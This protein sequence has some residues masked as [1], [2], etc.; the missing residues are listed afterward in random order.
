MGKTATL[1][2]VLVLFVTCVFTFVPVKGEYGTIVVPD[3]YATL[4]LAIQNAGEGD[5]VFV[6]KGTYQE[7]TITINKSISLIGEGVNETILSFNPPLVEAYILF[8][9]LVWVPDTAIKIEANDVKLQGFTIDLPKENYGVFNGIHAVGDGISLIDNEVANRSTVYLR[10]S[11]LNVTGNLM[12]GD[13]EVAGSNITIANN[14]I[15]QTLKV[16]GTFN[17]I[18]ANKIGGGYYF[19]CIHLI[20]S[21]NCV[22]D[23]SFSSMEMKNSSSNFIV[24]NSFMKLDLTKFDGGCFDNIIS[25]NQVKGNFGVNDGIWLWDGKNNIITANNIRNCETG[26]TLGT[27]HRTAGENSIYL[28]NFVNN[29]NHVVSLSG[30]NHTVNRFDNGTKGNY[31]DDYHGNDLNW[32]GVGD[33]PYT[34]K[35]THWDEEQQKDVTI[36]FFQDNYP[37]MSTFDIE[38]FSVELPEWAHT[39][40]R[41]LPDPETAEP[42]PTTLFIASVITIVAVTLGLLAYFKKRKH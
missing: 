24:G 37:L 38:G 3:D 41:H 22:V 9:N 16:Q 39:T 42:F 12:L 40:L 31:Y 5:T 13:L 11:M 34:V 28:N 6:K 29:N 23:N 17:V 33:T 14:T 15:K 32:D 10:G 4:S 27:T 1:L 26:L 20:G 2:L 18:S 19:N 8:Y 25:K 36:V 30:S 7:E 21:F 35:E